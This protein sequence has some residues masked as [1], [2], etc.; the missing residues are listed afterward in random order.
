[1]SEILTQMFSLPVQIA[2]AVVT[3]IV[4]MLYLLCIVWVFRDARE[5]NAPAFMWAIIAIIPVAGLVAY[6]LLRPP[7]TVLDR[8]EQYMQLDLLQR[9]L[10]EYSDCPHCGYPAQKD[11]VVCPRC[12]QQLRNRCTRCGRTLDP[13][14]TMCPYCTQPVGA[15]APPARRGG[16]PHG[17]KE[18]AKQPSSSASVKKRGSSSSASASPGSP[19][20]SPSAER[21]TSQSSADARKG[22]PRRGKKLSGS[23]SSPSSAKARSSK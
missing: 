2:L 4:I 20:A 3:I 7:L 9:Q 21:T 16:S 17:S 19:S 15:A 23:S 10:D 1:M 22:S 13:E 11:F 14:W 8:D 5:R 6:C 12:H 18:P